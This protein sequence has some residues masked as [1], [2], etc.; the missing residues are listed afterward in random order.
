[1]LQI[2]ESAEPIS[3]GV[4]TLDVVNIVDAAWSGKW[5]HAEGGRLYKSDLTCE[6]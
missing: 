3:W 1:M 4:G 6:E 5:H 2:C